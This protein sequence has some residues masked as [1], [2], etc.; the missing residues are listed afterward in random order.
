MI[1]AVR[2]CGGTLAYTAVMILIVSPTLRVDGE[3]DCQ[4]AMSPPHVVGLA[5]GLAQSTVSFA[6][7]FG[8]VIGG[9]VSRVALNREIKLTNRSGRPVSMAIHLDTHLVSTL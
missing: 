3:T 5:N 9:A 2:Y 6:R 4:N 8:P 1:R 7:F